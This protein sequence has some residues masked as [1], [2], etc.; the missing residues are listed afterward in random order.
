[1]RPMLLQAQ[2]WIFLL[3][4]T[5]NIQSIAFVMYKDTYILIYIFVS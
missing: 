5:K 3:L 2:Q 4:M 1:M